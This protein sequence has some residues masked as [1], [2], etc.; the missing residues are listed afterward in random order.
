MQVEKDIEGETA[1]AW[2][3]NV[4]LH[5]KS[6]CVWTS[7][8]LGS[9][10]CILDVSKQSALR[11]YWVEPSRFLVKGRFEMCLGLRKP[12]VFLHHELIVYFIT[13]TFFFFFVSVSVCSGETSRTPI[14]TIIPRW[15]KLSPLYVSLLSRCLVPLT[16]PFCP[17]RWNMCHLPLLARL[18]AELMEHS[19]CNDI[20]NGWGLYIIAGR[21]REQWPWIT[22]LPTTDQEQMGANSHSE[23]GNPF[24]FSKRLIFGRRW[25]SVHPNNL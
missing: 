5:W 12:R 22:I 16:G 4:R 1:T 9:N 15:E 10:N 2:K 3:L 7:G 8:A 13:H 24:Y 17:G 19:P 18:A 14:K 20:S 23:T 11:A 6:V 21:E 25:R